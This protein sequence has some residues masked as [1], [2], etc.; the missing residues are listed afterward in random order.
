MNKSECRLKPGWYVAS[1]GCSP[2]EIELKEVRGPYVR[3]TWGWSSVNDWLS[4]RPEPIE[5]PSLWRR[6]LDSLPG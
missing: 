4:S 2:E 1:Y 3:H 6:F 5:K